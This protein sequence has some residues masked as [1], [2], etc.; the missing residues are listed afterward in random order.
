MALINCDLQSSKRLMRINRMSPMNFNLSLRALQVD[1]LPSN[2]NLWKL[3]K[4][5]VTSSIASI[6]GFKASILTIIFFIYKRSKSYGIAVISF[7]FS[8]V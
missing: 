8:P 7:D 2:H 1:K 5:R 3:E 4:V 6:S